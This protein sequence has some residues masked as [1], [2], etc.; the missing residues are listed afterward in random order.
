MATE[1]HAEQV[2]SLLRPPW[3]LEAREARE[4]GTLSKQELRQ[5]EDRAIAELIDLQEQAGLQV[6]TDGEAR[7]ESGRA[8]LME[9]LDGVAPAGRTM[10]WYRDGRER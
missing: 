2:G 8:G 6:F 4:N 9:S 5:V 10:R 1:Y 7:R 3:L